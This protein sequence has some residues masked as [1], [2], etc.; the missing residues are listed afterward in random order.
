[1]KD[2]S[3]VTPQSSNEDSATNAIDAFSARAFFLRFSFVDFYA[4]DFCTKQMQKRR[5]FMYLAGN[6]VIDP[7]QPP[8]S[9]GRCHIVNESDENVDFAFLF[10][11][12][13]SEH[14]HPQPVHDM[15]GEM[16]IEYNIAMI[17]ELI[18]DGSLIDISD[19]LL[20]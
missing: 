11:I 3:S 12:S 10:T 14:L 4:A 15:D 1:L 2:S 17:P 16:A 13:L 9:A 7:F 6:A 20:L 19:T 8:T 18:P 5:R